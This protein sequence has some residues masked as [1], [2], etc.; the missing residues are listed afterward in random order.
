[1]EGEKGDECA[2][3]DDK[4]GGDAF[5]R[6]W[7]DGSGGGLHFPEIKGAGERGE[8]DEASEEDERAKAEVDGDLPSDAPAVATAEHADHEEGGD[9]RHFVEGV[10][11]EE[12]RGGECAD[13]SGG[14]E[15]GGAVVELLAASG[16]F[17]RE[18]GGEGDDDG[19]EHHDEAHAVHVAE[20]EVDG[21]FLKDLEGKIPCI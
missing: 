20:G 1:M 7:I 6:G 8:P 9:E 21:G 13:G 14:D 12:I 11:E 2:E 10:E 16:G 18:D 15:E 5:L 19:E 17:A 4:E 3:A